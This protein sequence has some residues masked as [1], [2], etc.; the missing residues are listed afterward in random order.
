MRGPKKPENVKYI[1]VAT[2]AARQENA[3][4]TKKEKEKKEEYFWG[5]EETMS[6]VG[7]LLSK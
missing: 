2:A 6:V 7:S 3:E 4:K 5:K 1:N